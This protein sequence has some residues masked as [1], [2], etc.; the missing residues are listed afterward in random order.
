MDTPTTSD[1]RSAARK[2][3]DHPAVEW[4]ARLGYAASGL[5][6]LLIAYVALRVAW[7]GGGGGTADQSG[8]LTQLRQAPGG[9]LVLWL[10]V[11]GFVLLA[12]WQLSEA[13]T[14]GLGGETSDRVKAGAKFVVYLALAWTALKFATGSSSSSRQQTKDFTAELLQHSGGRLLVGLIGLVIVAVGG[15]HVYKGWKKKFIEDLRENPGSWAVHAGRIGYIAK[16]VAF[17]VLGGLFVFAGVKKAP[18][19][20]TGLDGALRT[21]RDAP[22]GTALL[23]VVAIGIAAYGIYSF[24][25]A[26]AARV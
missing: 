21:L 16:G 2:A 17:V 13:V 19:K 1:V 6:H 14:G 8:A 24:A 5:I 9:G 26:R 15:Y 12:V 11:A 18:S 22:L 4:G 7:K 20:A 25:R 23:T 10:C 3:G